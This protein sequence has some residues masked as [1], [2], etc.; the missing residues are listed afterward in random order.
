MHLFETGSAD[1]KRAITFLLGEGGEAPFFVQPFGGHALQ[2][3][4]DIRK[5]VG[6]S[7]A[8]QNVNVIGHTSDRVHEPA[9]GA[10]NASQEV[11]EPRTAFRCQPWFP[12]FCAEDQVV[13]QREV[14]RRYGGLSGVPAG[15]HL[16]FW[17]WG[18]GIRWFGS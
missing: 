10:Q 1:C 6:G 13:M 2:P 14:C 4:H 17:V 15:T 18:V 5:A 16:D 9:F 7:E 11:M 12:V 8:R 3:L